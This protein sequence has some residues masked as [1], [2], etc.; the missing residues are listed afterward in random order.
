M[1]SREHG[2]FSRFHIELHRLLQSL[3]DRESVNAIIQ[4]LAFTSLITELERRNPSIP[5]SRY[6]NKPNP[7]SP[8]IDMVWDKLVELAVDPSSIRSLGDFFLCVTQEEKLAE[9]SELCRYLLR[10]SKEKLGHHAPKL[11]T[12]SAWVRLMREIESRDL[13]IMLVGK[14]SNNHRGLAREIVHGLR[15]R[16]VDTD[17]LTYL[18]S[19]IQEF[20]RLMK[21]WCGHSGHA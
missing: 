1:N 6:Y 15:V 14:A 16:R 7:S 12:S 3:F 19:F 10:L 18:T 2:Q 9:K 8:A 17:T 4:S 5:A 13:P 21:Q 20:E 11:E